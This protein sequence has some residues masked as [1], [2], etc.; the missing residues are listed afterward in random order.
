MPSGS[1]R[2]RV[3]RPGKVYL[4]GAGPGAPDLL[5]LRGLRVLRRADVLVYDRLVDRRLL[6]EA[7]RRALRIFAGKTSGHH[8][9]EQQEINALLVE[10][11]RRGCRVVR[12]KGGDPF[13]FGRGGEE[14]LALA[15]A[16]IAVEVVPGVSAAVAVPASAGIPV[17]HRGLSSSFA[18]VTGHEDTGK[19]ESRVD[20]ARLATAVDTIVVLMAAGNLP[21]IIEQLLRHGRSPDTPVALIRSGTTRDEETITGTLGDVLERAGAGRLCPPVTVVIGDVVALRNSLGRSSEWAAGDDMLTSSARVGP[22]GRHQGWRGRAW[23]RESGSSARA[24]SDAS[25]VGS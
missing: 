5:T 6:D 7:P 9:L 20:W 22:D 2:G 13:V 23:G 11:A 25:W 4:V 10:H 1:A 19:A 8:S 12:L 17:T 3:M 14:A 16:G 21:R 18:V 24:P 15:R